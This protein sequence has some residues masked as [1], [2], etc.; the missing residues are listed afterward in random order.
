MCCFMASQHNCGHLHQWFA[1]CHHAKHNQTGA[2]ILQTIPTWHYHE[3]FPCPP[4]RAQRDAD[5]ADLLAGKGRQTD[6]E[7]KAAKLERESSR[8]S[9]SRQRPEQSAPPHIAHRNLAEPRSKETQ[10]QNMAE[11]ALNLPLNEPSAHTPWVPP[12]RRQT[13]MVGQLG[14]SSPPQAHMHDRTSTRSPEMLSVESS[15]RP[16]SAA[17]PP[18]PHLEQPVSFADQKIS[19]ADMQLAHVLRQAGT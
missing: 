13:S 6:T 4:C 15:S 19:A 5:T 3:V 7:L 9:L 18:Y 10:L 14:S 17:S 2:C 12:S 1:R 8:A 16:S 11:G